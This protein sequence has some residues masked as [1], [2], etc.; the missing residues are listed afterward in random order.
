MALE[1]ALFSALCWLLS[2]A[3]RS[4]AIK[5]QVVDI[6]GERSSHSQITPRGGGLA[7]VI[8]A[9]LLA[10]YLAQQDPSMTAWLIA[11][12]FPASALGLFSFVDDH[13]PLSR[14]LRMLVH[15]SCATLFLYLLPTTSSLQIASFNIAINSLWALPFSLIAISWLINLYNFMD[16]IDGIAA[17]EAICLLLG[18]QIIITANGAGFD[19]ILMGL[20]AVIS[21]FLFINW[22]PAKVFMGDIGSCF[23][24]LVLA[25]IAC[26]CSDRY[27]ISL[28][29]AIILLTT[30][31]YDASWT[32]LYRILSKQ[33]WNEPHRSHSYQILSRRWESHGKVVC[34]MLAVN[35]FWLLPLAMLAN[36]Y[37][38]WGA[39]IFILAC[40]PFATIGHKLKAGH[41]TQ[42]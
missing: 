39:A 16:G 27:H 24:G 3:V 7:I 25:A 28:W 19:Q 2:H 18:L 23:L 14:R 11:I 36:H 8:C 37:P 31:I 42:L 13:R 6:P 41:K 9:C 40:L 12:F 26:Y 5:A 34:A 20:A 33:A 4:Y 29:S 22:A 32:L 21:G 30:F 10:I 15:M 35:T 1:L 17:S 38:A